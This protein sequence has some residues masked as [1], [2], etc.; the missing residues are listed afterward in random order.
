MSRHPHLTT[1]LAS[2]RNLRLGTLVLL[3]IMVNQIDDPLVDAT[4]FETLT[5][6]IVRPVVLAC[7]L[8]L[9]DGLIARTLAGRLERPEWLKPVVL[10]SA[11]GLLP[12]A[13]TEALLEFS[14]PMRPEFLD[15]ELWAQSP[16]L[17]L[18]GEYLTVASIIIPIHLLLWLI[19]D[20][21][22]HRTGGADAEDSRPAPEF[23]ARTPGL[24]AEDVLALQAEEHYVRIYSIDGAELVHYRFGNAVEEMPAELGLQVHRSWWVAG[25]AVRSATRGARRWQ[26]ELVNDVSVPV[27]DSYAN[28]VRERGWLK[29][30]PRKKS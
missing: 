23:L 30:K 13:L 24:R 28:A 15:D 11:L 21:N 6:W 7:G 26:L 5:Y 4:L 17:A 14:L 8:W 3:L 18:L 22:T 2:P 27:S 10:V 12:F 25:N 19:I 9:A 29:R 1:D 16:V 20:R